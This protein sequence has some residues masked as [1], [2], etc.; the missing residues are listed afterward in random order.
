[1][2]ASFH[3]LT[4]LWGVAKIATF[5]Q[6]VRLSY[7]IEARSPDLANSSGLP[8]NAMIFH[9]V[10]NWKVARDPE[11]QAMRRRMNMLLLAN[12][13]GFALLATYIGFAE[14]PTG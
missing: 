6:A 8:R 11:T 1:M 5:I 12:L 2:G 10:L 13:A 7:R 4:G 9:T 14:S 3:I